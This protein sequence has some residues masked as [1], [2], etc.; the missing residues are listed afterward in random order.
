VAFVGDAAR[1]KALLNAIITAKEQFFIP[2]EVRF[3][4]ADTK[5]P[6]RKDAIA[7]AAPPPAA[8][9]PTT[10]PA[11]PPAGTAAPAPSTT[12]PPA[13]TTAPGP[14]TPPA[15][16]AA[17]APPASPGLKYIVGTEPVTAKI[18]IE[19]VDFAEP[20]NPTAKQP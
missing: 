20:T 13:G 19:L 18:K 8:P 4:N 3:E 7:V 9:D 15:A 6:E 2:R 10:P 16:T 17:P 5:G 11:T 12:P 1:I 14:Q